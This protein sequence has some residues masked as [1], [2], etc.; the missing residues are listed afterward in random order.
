MISWFFIYSLA[1]GSGNLFKTSYRVP[2]IDFEPDDSWGK[3]DNIDSHIYFVFKIW[4]VIDAFGC[5]P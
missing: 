1:G 5:K 2:S 3:I 4:L